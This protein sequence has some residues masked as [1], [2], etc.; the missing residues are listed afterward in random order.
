MYTPA[1]TIV[2]RSVCFNAFGE[3]GSHG[4]PS[5]GAAVLDR[6]EVQVQTKRRFSH[7]LAADRRA[8]P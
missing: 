5:R 1:I 8:R 6:T 7:P 3:C 2:P 4:R